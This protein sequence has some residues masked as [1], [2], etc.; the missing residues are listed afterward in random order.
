MTMTTSSCRWNSAAH[1]A[2]SLHSITGTI[3]CELPNADVYRFAGNMRLGRAKAP[4]ED[5]DLQAT[6]GEDDESSDSA[7]EEEYMV[8]GRREAGDTKNVLAL[9]DNNLL[10]R[11]SVLRRCVFAVCDATF[12]C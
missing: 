4:V 6:R 10:L 12:V 5:T 1:A 11:G 8:G 3:K 7:A 9:D 2:T